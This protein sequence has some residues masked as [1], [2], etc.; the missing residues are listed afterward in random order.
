MLYVCILYVYS[1]Q[2]TIGVGLD[3]PSVLPTRPAPSSFQLVF[4]CLTKRIDDGAD[5][6]P[7][8]SPIDI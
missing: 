8:I 1:S 4:A 6:L 3:K 7:T 2:R 5:S